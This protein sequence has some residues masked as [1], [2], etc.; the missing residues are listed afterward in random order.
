MRWAP[1]PSARL[2]WAPCRPPGRSHPDT[3]YWSY[4]MPLRD[5][6]DPSTMHWSA[7]DD[8][9]T[10][11]GPSYAMLNCGSLATPLRPPI[12][13]R[14]PPTCSST[15]STADRLR[16]GA[17]GRHLPQP[18]GVLPPGHRERRSPGQHGKV[19]CGC[20]QQAVAVRYL[21][22]PYE[23]NDN[24]FPE[25]YVIPVDAA[26]QR[27]PADAYAMAVVLLRSGR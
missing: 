16:H 5:D 2:P 14:H 4:Y 10:N 19:V 9:C 22:R 20:E 25:Y 26:S 11:Y 7:W 27:D 3:L 1:R 24:Y 8:L 15:A 17:Q 6:Y 12:T 18:T 13:T 23:E 21:A